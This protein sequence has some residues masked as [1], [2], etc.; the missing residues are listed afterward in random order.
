VRSTLIICKGDPDLA[1]GSVIASVYR[2][3]LEENL[4]TLLEYDTIFMQDNAPIHTSRLVR[5]FL[6]EEGVTQLW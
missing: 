4:P 5:Q 3:I 6:E 1:R 2:D